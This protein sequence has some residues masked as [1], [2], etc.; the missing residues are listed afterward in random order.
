LHERADVAGGSG[1][2]HVPPGS[3]IVGRVSDTLRIRAARPRDADAVAEVFIASFDTL[4]FLPKLH[5]NEETIDFIASKVM[6]EQEVLVAEEDGT[7]VGFLAMA[8]GNTL[9]HLYVRPDSQ[10]RGVGGALLE[11]A[12]E[13]MPGGFS[14]WVF[15]QNLRAR[16]FYERHGLS[17]IERTEG[18]GNEERMPDARYEW[19]PDT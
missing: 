9:E 2:S 3:D 6:R 17:L 4:T 16:R 19:R 13:R 12:K 7:I 18:A 5:S 14:L 1:T 8:N 10:G 15:Q 11:R